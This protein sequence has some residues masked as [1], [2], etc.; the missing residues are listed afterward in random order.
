[1]I[2]KM[3]YTEIH[4]KLVQATLPCCPAQNFCI[5]K[6]HINIRERDIIE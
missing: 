1:M 6:P 2:T 4:F 3:K 5:L